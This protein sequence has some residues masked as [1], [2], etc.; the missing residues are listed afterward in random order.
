M[1]ISFTPCIS[2]NIIGTVSFFRKFIHGC[3]HGLCYRL[4]AAADFSDSHPADNTAVIRLTVILNIFCIVDHITRNRQLM[5][6][7]CQ[8][9]AEIGMIIPINDHTV[10][11]LLFHILHKFPGKSNFISPERKWKQ[12]ISFHIEMIFFVITAQFLD[13]C[14]KYLNRIHFRSRMQ[15]FLH[16]FHR[17]CLK[18]IKSRSASTIHNR[19]SLHSTFLHNFSDSLWIILLYPVQIVDFFHIH[20][21][22]YGRN[23]LFHILLYLRRISGSYIYYHAHK[24]LSGR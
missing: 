13:W 5:A 14:F 11:V 8:Y 1:L 15:K 3:L 17:I 16:F 12:I 10:T 7:S 24:I 19:C 23:M 9:P 22:T 21:K 4:F 18:N 2:V 20:Q 6:E